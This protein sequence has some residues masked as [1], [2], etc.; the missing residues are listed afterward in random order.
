[1]CTCCTGAMYA[2]FPNGFTKCTTGIQVV[3]SM[4]TWHIQALYT[5]LVNL[6]HL[7]VVYTVGI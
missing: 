7:Q 3:N 6:V 4:Y 5:P 2:N 1:M